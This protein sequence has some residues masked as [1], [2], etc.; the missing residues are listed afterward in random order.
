M[1]L[2]FLKAIMRA[3]KENYNIIYVDETGCYLENNNYRDW[4]NKKD[5]FIT[6]GENN[7]K[8]KINI[9][10]AISLKEI[11]YYKIV[12]SSVDPKEFCAFLIELSKRL[13]DEQKRK[14][15][16]VLDNASYHK[17]KEIIKVYHE[18]KLKI[19]TNIPYQSEFNGQ[20]YFFGFFKNMYYKYIYTNKKSNW[21]R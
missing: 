16:I 13:T 5:S 9:I 12:D 20:E 10:A 14:C 1:H 8:N 2:L 21:K 6:G 11:I 17:T 7:L 3:I 18:N 15:L 4:L 19:I